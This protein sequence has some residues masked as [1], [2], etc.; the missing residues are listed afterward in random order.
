MVTHGYIVFKYKG[1]CY[2]FYNHSDSY[3]EHLGNVV[4]NEIHKMVNK[5]LIKYYKSLLLRVPLK[6]NEEGETS[7]YCF[8]S[9]LTYPDSYQYFTSKKEEGCEYTYTIDFDA[10]KFIA[11]R[12]GENIYS[13]NLY[14]VPYNWYEITKSYSSYDD[15]DI[16]IDE[17]EDSDDDD[18]I[19][20][21]I[22]ELEERIQKLKLKLNSKRE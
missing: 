18:K 21:K 12:Y 3:F 1:M 6:G 14:D 17:S 19:T 5:N 8:H 15:D 2:N 10:C 16:D 22:Q 13:F 7:I 11:N 9:L 4:V 20:S